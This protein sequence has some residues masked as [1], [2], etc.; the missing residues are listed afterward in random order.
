MQGNVW[1]RGCPA[2]AL[3]DGK[4]ACSVVLDRAIGSILRNPK[5]QPSDNAAIFPK[6]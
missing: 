3:T 1:R 2:V 4:V 6:H 5:A